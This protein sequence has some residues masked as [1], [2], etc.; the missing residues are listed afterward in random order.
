MINLNNSR[1]SLIF[2][3]VGISLFVAYISYRIFIVNPKLDK[4]YLG[5]HFIVNGKITQLYE[6][7]PYL[8]INTEIKYTVDEKEYLTE[9]GY[10]AP[11][12]TSDT[13]S[14]KSRREILLMNIPMAVSSKNH[15][16]SIPLIRPE[17]F[18][19]VDRAFPDSLL[20]MYEK[21][22]KCTFWEGLNT[23]D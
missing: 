18:T 7:G 6:K 20:Y 4:E 19:I 3:I 21:Y 12:R 2:I 23:G 9:I 15:G 5:D 13:K 10:Q 1:N 11:C 17:D 14:E 22:F 16:Y 8:N